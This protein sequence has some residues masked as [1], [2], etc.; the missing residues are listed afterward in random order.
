M[1]KVGAG[2][3]GA[4]GGGMFLGEDW[5]RRLGGTSEGS[6]EEFTAR[7]DGSFEATGPA[8]A[9]GDGDV[10]GAATITAVAPADTAGAANFPG[11]A[12][13]VGA[14]EGVNGGSGADAVPECGQT[15]TDVGRLDRDKICIVGGDQGEQI[16]RSSLT[17]APR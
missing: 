12:D 14:S 5:R 17:E 16:E 1:C 13:D 6:L 9:K 3:A 10:W 11:V 15:W 4:T 7:S 8:E 2:R